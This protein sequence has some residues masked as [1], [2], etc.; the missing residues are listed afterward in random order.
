MTTSLKKVETGRTEP[1]HFEPDPSIEQFKKKARARKL[2]AARAQ[3]GRMQI[4]ADGNR[5][6]IRFDQGQRLALDRMHG[7][8]SFT[9]QVTVGGYTDN[10]QKDQYDQKDGK[11]CQIELS[12]GDDG[13]GRC[14]LS[15][16]S[17]CNHNG[18]SEKNNTATA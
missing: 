5:T 12:T 11:G 15:L 18:L 2:R 3:A 17:R 14:I 4:E 7:G 6:F 8:V 13:H 16:R 9:V 10:N 1:S